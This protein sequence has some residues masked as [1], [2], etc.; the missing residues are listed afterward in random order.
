MH[1]GGFRL[2]EIV[3]LLKMNTIQFAMRSL[4][5]HPRQCHC[6][7]VN[8]RSKAS[9]TTSQQDPDS[10]PRLQIVP[11]LWSI[12]ATLI[13]STASRSSS[14]PVSSKASQHCTPTN[15]FGVPTSRSN[16]QTTGETDTNSLATD[17]DNSSPQ[18]SG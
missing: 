15:S 2:Y 6:R 10:I 17:N 18:T 8:Y 13:T 5:Q 9:D 12:P 4:P 3:L 11:R 16:S 7:G 1:F 14:S